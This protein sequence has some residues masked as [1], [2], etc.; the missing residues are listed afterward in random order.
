[1]ENI[2]RA[3]KRHRFYNK[4]T[5]LI[6]FF[7]V[8]Y[9]VSYYLNIIS[10]FSQ[11]SEYYAADAVSFDEIIILGL[12]LLISGVLVIIIYLTR[13][14]LKPIEMLEFRSSWTR[15]RLRTAWDERE[16]D[17]VIINHLKSEVTSFLEQVD[18][19]LFLNKKQLAVKLLVSA[20]LLAAF[21]GL[22][23]TQTHLNVT[24]DTVNQIIEELGGKLPEGI[25]SSEDDKTQDGPR[26]EDLYGDVSVASIAGENVELT[27]IPG[28]GTSVTIRNTGQEDTVQFVPSQTYPVDII[29]SAAA[30]ESYLAIQQLS[31]QDR[32]LI[33]DYAILRSKLKKD[34]SII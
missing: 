23:D 31:S 7:L 15:E 10:F 9:A 24:P 26:D 12:S 34:R 21:L 16:E 25:V 19:G 28:L 4:V 32:D 1:M 2:S 22:A 6:L 30:D 27:I 3:F 13:P 18:T 8:L 14:A 11:Y 17:N 20:V 5:D 29:S 33:K